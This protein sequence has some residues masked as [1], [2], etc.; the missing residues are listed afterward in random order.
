MG[1]NCR[2]LTIVDVLVYGGT[3]IKWNRDLGSLRNLV[4]NTLGFTGVWKSTGGKSK[5]FTNSNSDVIITWYPGK[6]NSLTFNGKKGEAV[7]KALVRSTDNDCAKNATLSSDSLC[8]TITNTSVDTETPPDFM[9]TGQNLSVTMNEVV[10]SPTVNDGDV[11]GIR[12]V[13]GVLASDCS[14]LEELENFIDRS[15]KNVGRLPLKAIDGSTPSWKLF[16]P[17]SDTLEERFE[18]LKIEIESRVLLLKADRSEQTQIINACKQGI[19]KLT[20]ENFIL[21]SRL[22]ELEEKVFVNKS[23]PCCK[24]NAQMA[25]SNDDNIQPAMLTVLDSP[26]VTIR[27]SINNPLLPVNEQFIKHRE[28]NQDDFDLQSQISRINQQKKH[29]STGCDRP[30]SKPKVSQ[31][32]GRPT[33]QYVADQVFAVDSFLT[34]D[35]TTNNPPP[36]INYSSCESDNSVG[37]FF[38]QLMRRQKGKK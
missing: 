26:T 2:N 24:G 14:T 32:S 8:Y 13:D 9:C 21:K 7:K 29:S 30:S 17:K 34:M 16:D 19:C 18:T 15:F 28:N 12:S 35:Q 3:R 6:L 33:S 10:K 25:A 31:L 4:E 38:L 23:I 36:S 1:G 27:Q 20:N 5:Q 22:S 37:E 11:T